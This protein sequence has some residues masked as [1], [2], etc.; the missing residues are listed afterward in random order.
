MAHLQVGKN[1]DKRSKYTVFGYT[2]KLEESLKLQTIPPIVLY[3]CIAYIYNPEFFARVREDAFKISDDKLSVTNIQE[4]LWSQHCIYL[5]Q[6]IESTSK[7]IVTWIFKMDKMRGGKYLASFVIISKEKDVEQQPRD[8][9][10]Y[11]FLDNGSIGTADK[12]CAS[13]KD[14]AFGENDQVKIKLNLSKATVSIQ[15]NDKDEIICDSAVQIS[16]DIKYKMALLLSPS[17]AI[18][19]LKEFTRVSE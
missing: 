9:P 3:L 18:V 2:R 15:I 6:W 1:A 19:S 10:Y 13:N 4:I 8:M 14:A 12:G 7:S 16:E 17:D 5:N 11:E